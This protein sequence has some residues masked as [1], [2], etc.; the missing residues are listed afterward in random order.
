MRSTDDRR[1]SDGCPL[2]SKTYTT[3]SGDTWDVIAKRALGS[4]FYMDLMIEAN[5]TQNYVAR[6]DGGV[7]LNVPPLPEPARPKSLPTWRRP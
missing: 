2:P 3:V 1:T 5:P 4:E 6:F 7:E